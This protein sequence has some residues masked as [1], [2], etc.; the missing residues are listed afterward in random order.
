MCQL[1]QLHA[2]LKTDLSTPCPLRSLMAEH[3]N[4]VVP[5]LPLGLVLGGFAGLENIP[6]NAAQGSGAHDDSYAI[7]PKGDYVEKFTI[8]TTIVE[9]SPLT[10]WYEYF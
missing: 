1:P 6:T 8:A 9:L 3:A 2:L 7:L 10:Q 4:F 5:H